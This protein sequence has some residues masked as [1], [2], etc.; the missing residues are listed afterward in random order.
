MFPPATKNT[1]F[2]IWNSIKFVVFLFVVGTH[3][4]TNLFWIF[5]FFLGYQSLIIKQILIY[6]CERFI[7]Y[8]F[9]DSLN[10]S[11]C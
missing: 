11:I 8:L 5:F 4:G 3:N 1:G 2:R 10:V 7:M 6:K 9:Q